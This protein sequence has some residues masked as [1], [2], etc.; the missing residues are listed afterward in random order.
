MPPEGPEWCELDAEISRPDEFPIHVERHDLAV[1]EPG[2]DTLTVSSWRRCRKVVLFVDP[3]QGSGRLRPLLPQPPAVRSAERLH[4]EPHIA[5]GPFGVQALAANRLLPL[6]E[7]A[8][9]PGQLRV[10]ITSRGRRR[11]D[12]RRDDHT[13]APDDRA[14]TCRAP[15]AMHAT[16]CSR[17][18]STSSGGRI[19]KRGP[20]ST[21]RATAASSV[22]KDRMRPGRS[23]PRP[24]TSL[25]SPS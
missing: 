17:S 22:Q 25:D 7:R 16:R 6:G 10:G 3:R 1:A 5:R 2:V 13:I 8:F 12:L 19:P 4:D 21:A 24:R 9:V 18:C 11:A 15:R 20:D 14:T 23:R